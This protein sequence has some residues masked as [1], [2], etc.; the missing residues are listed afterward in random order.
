VLLQS[1]GTISQPKFG[2]GARFRFDPDQPKAL[3]HAAVTAQH[4]V[5]SRAPPA[6]QDVGKT[7][8]R[9]WSNTLSVCPIVNAG[10]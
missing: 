6:E 5:M 1:S 9:P 7:R 8:M 4:A 10:N 3:L 2:M